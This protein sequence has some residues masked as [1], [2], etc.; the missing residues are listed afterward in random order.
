MEYNG[1]EISVW[2]MEDATMGWNGRFQ[3]WNGIQSSIL[4]YQ[5]H[6]RFFE[7]YL[8]KNTVINKI[9]T[10]VFNLNI[11]AYYLSTNRGTLVVYILRKK[12]TYS[13][14]VSTLQFAALML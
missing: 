5:F 8:Q 9:V 13:I 10:Q 4:P 3:E 14:I 12:G 11:Y 1:T 6:I 2:T 7:L